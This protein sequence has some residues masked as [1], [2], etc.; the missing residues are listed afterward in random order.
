MHKVELR[1]YKVEQ[2][3]RRE[4]EIQSNLRHPNIIRLYGFFQDE[5][6]C[7]LLA[8][9]P[10]VSFSM[11]PGRGGYVLQERVFLILEYAAGGVLFKELTRLRRFD[12]PTSA[13]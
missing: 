4:I 12:E 5:V 10:T 1:K 7:G 11:Q 6:S 8:L 9:P 3:L 2:Q 13:K